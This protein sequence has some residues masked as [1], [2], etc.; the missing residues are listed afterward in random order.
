MA[1]L[2][3]ASVYC[4]GKLPAIIV[5]AVIVLT[6]KSPFVTSGIRIGTPAVTTRGLKEEDM[7]KIVDLIDRVINNIDKDSELEKVKAE[8]NSM[9]SGRPL[10]QM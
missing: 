7:A 5:S 1:A 8:V 6:A 3:S 10:F 2:A 9:M 4:V